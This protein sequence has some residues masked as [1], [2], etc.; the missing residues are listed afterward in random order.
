MNHE[1]EIEGKKVFLKKDKTGIRVIYPIKKNI[2]EPISLKNINWFNLLTG[3][4]WWKVIKLILIVLLILFACYTYK[5]DMENC[6]SFWERYNLINAI[7]GNIT[8]NESIIN[9]DLKN[10]S[11]DY[12]LYNITNIPMEN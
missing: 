9:E 2:E 10:G 3:G 1:I 7:N 11:I 12:K 8:L 4:S 5:H 6:E